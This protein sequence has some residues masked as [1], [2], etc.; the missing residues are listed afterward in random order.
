MKFSFLKSKTFWLSIIASV[1]AFIPALQETS[2][3]STEW[4]TM[5]LSFLVAVNRVAKDI[6]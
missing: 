6:Q 5:I 3:I 1:I 4:A 2:L